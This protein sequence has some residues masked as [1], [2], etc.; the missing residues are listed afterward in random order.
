[1]K[2]ITKISI[3]NNM[4]QADFID[5]FGESMGTHLV[6]KLIYE[7]D[8]NLMRLIPELDSNNL[9]LLDKYLEDKFIER[10]KVK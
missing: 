2:F 5:C 6:N 9:F 10:A 8:R 4:C 3:L 1:M 7:K